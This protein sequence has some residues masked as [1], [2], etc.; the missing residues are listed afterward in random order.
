M[1]GSSSED[2]A[3]TTVLVTGGCGYFGSQLIRDLA[4]DDRL[5]R[6]VVRIL[7]NFQSGRHEALLDLPLEGAFEF[8]EGDLL[9]P[10]SLRRVLSGVELVIHLAAVEKTPFSFENPVWLE[11]VNHWGTRHLVEACLEM[12]VRDVLLASTCAVYGPGGPFGETAQSRPMGPYAD[13]K[14]LAEETLLAAVDR[15]LRPIVARLGSLYG[16]APVMSFEAVANRLGYL[17]GVGRSLTVFGSGEQRRPLV[18]VRDASEAIRR[19]LAEAAS[20][21]AS[22]INVVAEN[23]SIVQIAETVRSL[24]PVTKLRF[25]DQDI[26]VHLSLIADNKALTEIGWR[27]RVSLRDGLGELM[28]RLRGLHPAEQD[29]G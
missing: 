29:L 1:I 20:R 13:S 12:G 16:V 19:L 27:P 26:R 24:R 2:R 22:P 23:P 15:G 3:K 11:Q 7:D 9:D 4:I 28:D 6:P 17:A 25:T 18:H 10:S 5:E 21:G 14:R 8:F